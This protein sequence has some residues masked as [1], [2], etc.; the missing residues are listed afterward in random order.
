[1]KPITIGILMLIIFAVVGNE[2]RIALEITLSIAFTLGLFISILLGM[3]VNADEPETEAEELLA[4]EGES[5][6]EQ[7]VSTIPQEEAAQGV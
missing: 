1:M 7:T 6:Q 5:L 3:K 2:A 4:L